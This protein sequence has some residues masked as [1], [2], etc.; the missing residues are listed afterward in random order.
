[1]IEESELRISH[2]NQLKQGIRNKMRNEKH[3]TER[4]CKV[5]HGNVRS[6]G[7]RIWRDGQRERTVL[8]QSPFFGLAFLLT[9][10]AMQKVRATPALGDTVE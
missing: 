2:I 4:T 5:E 10:L 1:V 7:T 8:Q 6:E 3:M 9:F